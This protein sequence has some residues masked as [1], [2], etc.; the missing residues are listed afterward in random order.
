MRGRQKSYLAFRKWA[1]SFLPVPLPETVGAAYIVYFD[2]AW[3]P[4]LLEA[5]P[6]SF[7]VRVNGILVDIAEE[8][9]PS[10]VQGHPLAREL[11]EL[12]KDRR[13][14]PG[15]PFFE[16]PGRHAL[17]RLTRFVIL[18]GALSLLTLLLALIVL[19]IV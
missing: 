3:G 5:A 16:M 11:R 12:A 7:Q 6:T 1:N 18:A 13:L 17:W 19:I 15:R 8:D 14:A 2:D 9:W 4:H 10:S